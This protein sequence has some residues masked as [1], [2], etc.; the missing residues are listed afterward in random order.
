MSKKEIKVKTDMKLQK[1]GKYLEDLVACLR[2]G[3]V[4]VVKGEDFVTLKP[5]DSVKLELEAESRKGKETLTLSVSWDI[6]KTDD[7][8]VEEPLNISSVPPSQS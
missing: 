5:A 7:E 2:V 3:T 1:L 6:D 8:P 4:C